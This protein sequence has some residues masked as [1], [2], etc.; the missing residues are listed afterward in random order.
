MFEEIDW[1]KKFVLKLIIIFVCIAILMFVIF[2]IIKNLNSGKVEKTLTCNDGTFYDSCSLNKPY[3][4]ANGNLVE[5]S[6]FCGCVRG[7]EIKNDSC[8]SSD[9]YKNPKIISLKYLLNGHEDYLNFTVYGGANNY[10][11]NI[12]KP[13]KFFTDEKAT[14]KDYK[15]VQINDPIQRELLISLVVQIQNISNNKDDQMRIATSLVQNLPYGS[16]NE[17]FKFLGQE[18]NYTRYPYEILYDGYGDCEEK[19]SLLVFLLKEIGYGTASFYYQQENHE[20]VGIACPYEKSYLGS[21]YCFIETTGPSVMTNYNG[22]YEFG[23]LSNP[24]IV[25]LSSGFSL[26]NNLYEYD[27]G[28]KMINLMN[29][30]DK[31][32]GLN[33][34]QNKSLEKIKKKYGITNV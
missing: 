17:M 13:Y 6:S 10:F 29:K 31:S 14:R 8:Y 24:E 20:S 12:S 9:L 28:Q 7:W 22:N 30:I 3:Y 15:L 18:I 32:G 21:G 16:S 26:E 11:L 34:F 33:Y 19:S 4:C 25:I 5:N 23:K 2:S 1:S 27:D